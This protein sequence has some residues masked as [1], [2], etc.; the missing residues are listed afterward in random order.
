MFEVHYLVD[1]LEQF[2]FDMIY[3]EHMMHHSLTSLSY[4]L[5]IFDMEIFDV[6]RIPIHA[7]SIRVH[8]Q[9]KNVGRHIV[10]PIVDDLFKIPK[11]EDL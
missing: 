2:Q 10:K 11:E 5:S 6:L 3:H 9:N 8:A 7:G 1:L 4:L